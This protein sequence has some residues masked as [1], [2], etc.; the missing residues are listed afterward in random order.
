[1]GFLENGHEIMNHPNSLLSFPN[2][3]G[4]NNVSGE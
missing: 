1:M 2:V 3:E 4:A